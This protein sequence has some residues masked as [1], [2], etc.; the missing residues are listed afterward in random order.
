LPGAGLPGVLADFGTVLILLAPFKIDELL[1]RHRWAMVL[2]ALSPVSIMVSG[3]HGN[4]DPVM[5]FFLLAAC[6]MAA[7]HQPILCGLLFALSCQVKII[8]VL[9]FPIFF[10]FWWN[11][12]ASVS[13]LLATTVVFLTLW[14]EPL[15]N[16]PGLFIRNVI[17][18]GSYWGLWGI[19][20]WL[21]LTGSP[22]FSNVW[23]ENFSLSQ[24]VIVGCLKGLIVA[25][26][27]VIAWRRR[28]L[29]ARSLIESIAYAW[30]LFYVFSPG[31]CAQYMV[32][33][34][35]FILVLSPK[36]YGWVTVASSV[37]LFFFYNTICHGLPWYLGISTNQL[38]MIWTP[39]SVWPW[40]ILI[41]GMVILWHRATRTNPGLRL[42]SLETL[43]ADA[44]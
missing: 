40:A 34:A 24:K 9:L 31:V 35:P 10:F 25:G 26:A 42:F 17:S 41:A 37:F 2:F 30:L 28:A 27:L 14:S 44:T 11:R 43:A 5:V 21:R 29:P 39:W 4:T 12:R 19:S 1:R 20:Y 23:Y 18:Y 13:F 16:F 7:R 6:Y 36:F 15:L 32:W 38:N 3:F 8:P 22:E 33:L